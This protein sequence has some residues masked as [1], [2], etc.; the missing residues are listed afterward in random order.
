MGSVRLYHLS[1]N[2]E[3]IACGILPRISAIK[4]T[5]DQF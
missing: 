2:V 3:D 1:L 5:N 4:Y